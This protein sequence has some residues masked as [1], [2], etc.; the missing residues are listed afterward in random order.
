MDGSVG[1]VTLA[2]THAAT[3]VVKEQA[4]A[5]L[6]ANTQT[7]TQEAEGKASRASPVTTQEAER[8]TE[9]GQIANTRTTTQGEGQAVADKTVNTGIARGMQSGKTK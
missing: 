1:A 8:Q 5:G 7:A 9:A 6:I 2:N 4:E 3:E